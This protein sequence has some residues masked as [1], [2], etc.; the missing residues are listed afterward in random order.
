V[1]F[2]VWV[3]DRLKEHLEAGHVADI[4]GRCMPLACNET[5][6]P[7]CGLHLEER[8]DLDLVLPVVARVVGVEEGL[9][10]HVPEPGG[11]RLIDLVG[12]DPVNFADPTGLKKISAETKP[13]DMI[14]VHP[15]G[16]E[17]A[18]ISVSVL[19]GHV[20]PHASCGATCWVYNRSSGRR[21]GGAWQ[22]SFWR[23]NASLPG[24]GETG[25]GGRGR[26]NGPSKAQPQCLKFNLELS[27]GAQ[28]GAAGRLGPIR[29][30]L[31]G[32]AASVRTNYGTD[33]FN[34][35]RS[36]IPS[37]PINTNYY[38]IVASQ[39]GSAGVSFLGF[40]LFHPSFRRLGS[41]GQREDP[42]IMLAQQPFA[43]DPILENPEIGI[44]LQLAFIIGVKA[45]LA[46][47][48]PVSGECN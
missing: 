24:G 3:G 41:V 20:P 40:N 47:E 8:E 29:A 34:R 22:S 11:A 48:L 12:G 2:V 45:E 44:G 13:I 36:L 39:G 17:N 5:R 37:R 35:S 32:D 10:R 1:F 14:V 7:V 33:S 23:A 27:L 4:F 21:A 15:V 18:P 43:F 9:S 26:G 28:A 19:S 16:P 6:Q 46:Q 42:S 31:F 25:S 38:D 30:S